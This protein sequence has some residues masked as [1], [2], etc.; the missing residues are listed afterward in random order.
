MD[1]AGGKGVRYGVLPSGAVILI[2]CCFVEEVL[3]S[4]LETTMVAWWNFCGTPPNLRGRV[5]GDKIRRPTL[6]RSSALRGMWHTRN[7]KQQPQVV[8]L[9]RICG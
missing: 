5:G 7:S 2:L 3:R 9:E 1:T 4:S 8:F 6:G